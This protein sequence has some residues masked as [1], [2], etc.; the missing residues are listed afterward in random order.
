[1]L[2]KMATARIRNN[3]WQEEEG[4]N[5]ALTR[6]VRENLCQ[7]EVLDFV[8][9]DFSDYAWSLRMLDRRL[10]YF[11]ITYTY[12]TVQVDE[13]EDAVKQEMQGPRK[14]LGCRALHKKLRQVHDLNVPRDLVYAVMYN[15]DPDALAERAPQYKKKE[16]QRQLHVTRT[17]LGSFS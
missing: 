2:F 16:G 9:R 4:L 13:V 6:Y 5:E 14:L 3:D 10:Q 1:M 17:K 8:S 12:Q 15:V 7:N 11:G